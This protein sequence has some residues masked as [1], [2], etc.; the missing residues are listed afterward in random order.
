MR[1][2]IYYCRNSCYFLSVVAKATVRA[3]MTPACHVL[4]VK[5]GLHRC[6]AGAQAI[7]PA[8]SVSTNAATMTATRA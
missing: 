4:G 1:T 3:T 2:Y 6:A 7:I 8:T 5:R